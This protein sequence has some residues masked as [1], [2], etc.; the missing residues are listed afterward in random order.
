[1]TIDN[2]QP[3]S[4]SPQ[5]TNPVY[6]RTQASGKRIRGSSN[7]SPRR[8]SPTTATT[9][10]LVS[11]PRRKPVGEYYR[12]VREYYGRTPRLQRIVY[13]RRFGPAFWTVA[14]VL[15]LIVNVILIAIILIL[16]RQLFNMRTIVSEG[17]LGGLYTNFVKMDQAHILTSVNVSST[18]QVQDQIPVVFDLPLN[19]NT[20]VVLTTPTSI[21]GATIFLNGAAVPLNLILPSGTSLN[22][23]MDMVVPVSATIPVA[24]D[25]PVNLTVP[26]DI[27]L[28][29]TELHDPFVGLQSV[30]RPYNELISETPSSWEEIEACNH[31]YSRWVCKIVFGTN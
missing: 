16:G 28:D 10:T 5:P 8:V 6:R 21:N 2:E 27:P 24:L 17:L 13:Q 1:M 4:Q 3:L 9:G 29:Q 11:T 18:I 15:S 26:V 14:S 19:Q 25:V 7:M 22:I 12:R 30:V 20:Q 31:W 23:G